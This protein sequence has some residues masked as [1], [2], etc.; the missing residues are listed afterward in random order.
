[1]KKCMQAILI[2][3]FVLP[4]LFC[5]VPI[6]AQTT[7]KAC[8]IVLVHGFMGFGEEEML[9]YNYWGGFDS[10]KEQLENQGYTVFVASV[11]PVSS[12]WDRACELFAQ[13]K[14]GPVDYGNGHSAFFNHDQTDSRKNFDGLY[15]QW[16]QEHPVHLIGHSQ[17]GQTIR[18]LAQLLEQGHPGADDVGY[19]ADNETALLLQGGHNNWITSIFMGFYT[20]Q[21]ID[22]SWLENDGVVNTTSMNGPKFNSTDVIVD[23]NGAPIK[24]VWNHLGCENLDHGDIVGIMSWPNDTPSGYETLHEWY[25]DLARMLTSLD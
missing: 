15:P 6:A 20:T 1:M 13:I 19:G 4:S 21:G 11:G 12:S 14:G 22:R 7:G 23:F 3:V 10:L 5:T 8:P 25:S 2:V 18:L 9:G 24:G 17:G 16:D